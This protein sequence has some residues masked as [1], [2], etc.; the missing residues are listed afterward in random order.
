MAKT[1]LRRH[2]RKVGASSLAVASA[3]YQ[4]SPVLAAIDN[5]ATASGAYGSPSTTYNSNSSPASV[6]VAPPNGAMTVA[7]T[8]AVPTVSAGLDNTISDAGDTITYTYVVNN[9]G[10][11]TL[12]GV[13]PVD[14]GPTF[15]GT[16]GTGSMSS[17]TLTSG[18]LPIAPGQSA[19]FTA[20]YTMSQLD[21]VRSA[22]VTN[23]VSN[24]ATA[25]GTRPGGFT[26]NS[27]PDTETTTIPAGP[28]L[29]I[30]KAAVLND[31]V[32]GTTGK[33]DLNETITYTYTVRNTGNVTLTGVSVDDTHEGALLPAGTVTD[34]TLTSD[35][36]LAPGQT[37]TDALASNGVWSVL[38]PGAVVT[39]TY[40]HTVTQTEINNG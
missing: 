16:A 14:T 30:T 22:G 23:D 12:S 31:N 40:T 3:I 15:G 21:V 11:V 7:K 5:S 20:T 25:T 17:F 38:R 19:T 28:K 34:E 36:P 4:V 27:P 6:P 26:V 8:A 35:G 29:L 37:S 18:T 10:N 9:T 2:L 24:T 13:T 33:A 32:G 1:K 39:F